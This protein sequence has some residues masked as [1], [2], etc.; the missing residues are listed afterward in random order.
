MLLLRAQ[1]LRRSDP[2]ALYS[3]ETPGLTPCEITLIPYFAWG[4]RQGGDMRVWIT[5]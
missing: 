2:E 3:A 5:E 4:N 1:G